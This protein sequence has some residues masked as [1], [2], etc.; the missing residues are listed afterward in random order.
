MLENLKRTWL[1]AALAA[2]AMTAATSAKAHDRDHNDDTA[3]IAI[4]AGII[5]LAVGAAIASDNDRY[6]R[7]RGPEYGY[8]YPPPRVHYRGYPRPYYRAYPRGYYHDRYP[9]RIYRYDPHW[10][11]RLHGHAYRHRGW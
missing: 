5:G 9:R 1:I 8:Y 11:R 7:Y 3:A 4:G 2:G 10:E 6:Y